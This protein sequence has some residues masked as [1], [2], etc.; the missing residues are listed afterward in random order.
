MAKVLLFISL[1]FFKNDLI[2]A[3]TFNKKFVLD[4]IDNFYD[5]NLKTMKKSNIN[6]YQIFYYHKY[7]LSLLV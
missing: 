6:Q 1:C 7:S 2:I 5:F 3:I 4:I